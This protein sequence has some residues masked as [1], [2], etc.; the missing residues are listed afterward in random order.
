MVKFLCGL[1]LEELERETGK[2]A[3][4]LA[5]YARR[6]VNIQMVAGK[7]I[8][9]TYGTDQLKKAIPVVMNPQVLEKIRNRERALKIW[10][11]IGF[12]E[13]AH[14]LWPA[15]EQYKTAHTEG[16]R[17]LF[18]LVD[19]EQN[20]RRGRALDPSWGACFQSVCAHIFPSR[21][22]AKVS[23][24]LTDGG[25][26]EKKPWGVAAH[27]VY[28]KRW[29]I[30]AYHFRRH[31]P[32]CKDP[33]VAKALALIPANF[34]DLEKEE[35]LKLTRQIHLAL[36]S[37]IEL[38]AEVT[39][40]EPEEGEE[41]EKKDE[42]KEKPEEEKG[43]GDDELPPPL[44]PSTWNVKKLLTSKWMLIPLAL[45]VLGW[46]VLFL[47]KDVDFW[48]QVALLGG[49]AF[50]AI[51]V[52]LYLRRAYIKAQLAALKEAMKGGSPA[53]PASPKRKATVV[54]TLLLL[55]LAIGVYALYKMGFHLSLDWL[56]M[57]GTLLLFGGFLYAGNLLSK[58]ADRKKEPLGWLT[59][60]VMVPCC[61][62]SLGGL[63]FMGRY[64]NLG[65][66]WLYSL[67]GMA[68]IVIMGMIVIM[69]GSGK[70]KHAQENDSLSERLQR[71][72]G[73][74]LSLPLRLAA[75]LGSLLWAI[76]GKPVLA[77]IGYV[78][79]L[80][81]ACL[82][83]IWGKIRAAASFVWH[84]IRRTYW[85]LQP[86]FARWWRNQYFRL[87]VVAMPIALIGV[88]IYA[89]IVKAASISWWL[90]AALILLLLLLLA[91]LWFFRKKISK[92]ILN[93]LFMPMPDLMQMFIQPPLD[94]KTDWFIQIDDV[95]QV[96]PDQE[97]VDELLPE[98][99]ALANQLRKYLA[100]CGSA[101]V[102]RED[103]PDGHDLVDEAELA[104]IGES[105]IFVDDDRYPRASVHLEVAL[106]CSGSMGSPT[107][108]LPAGEKFRLGKLF[109]MVIEQAVINLPGVSARFWGFTSDTIFD[110]G[111]AG[112]RKVSGLKCGG[113]N[114][115]AAMLWKMGQS[116]RQSGKDVKILLMLSDGQPSECSWL[117]LHNLV[118]KFEQEGMIP[119]N[120]GLDVIETPAFERFFTDLVG[121]SKDEAVLTMGQTL[122]AI[123]QS[124]QD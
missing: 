95:S 9:F 3:S 108:S 23:T 99:Y 118:L 30:F 53:P 4:D 27:E 39:P 56:F 87:A 48:V 22:Q 75:Y 89:L 80:I 67:V 84:H 52:F 115:D 79:R 124:S 76:T 91:L 35:L 74:L 40:P 97:V 49:L 123:A 42:K 18:N 93:E 65:E 16:F 37:G 14:H 31:M 70:S 24:G 69:L 59:Y 60:A 72:A 102:D 105:N 86:H 29:G 43:E 20:E 7:H 26:E 13:L 32:D 5:F 81:T 55:L 15:D 92:F 1:T 51:A 62:L 63:I 34:K 122:A 121:Q 94:M 119:W 104:L 112:E 50:S 120:F 19:D 21:D 54:L 45:F 90:V 17:H 100:D 8:A 117:S 71:G 12:H 85:K 96:Q 57:A 41:E 6:P 109:A 111:V 106:D 110:C 116:A 78:W 77:F 68:F 66:F 36:S 113:G 46:S 82:S 44:P 25:E 33:V 103:Q 11:G 83:F 61:L 73:P 47:Q 10:R 98:T 107:L 58:E 101:L 114:N 64:F 28:A 88:I 2:L 38:P